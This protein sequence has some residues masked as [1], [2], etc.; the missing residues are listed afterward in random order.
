VGISRSPLLRKAHFI[1]C[2]SSRS[3]GDEMSF[4][5]S[6]VAAVASYATNKSELEKKLDEALS[7]ENWGAP[8]TLLR[9]I[10]AATFDPLDYSVVMREVWESLNHSGTYCA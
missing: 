3:I 1:A 9:E 7:K 4:L 10:A 6:A 8:S 2:A 5:S